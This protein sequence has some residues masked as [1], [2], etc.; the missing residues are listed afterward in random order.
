VLLIVGRYLEM[1]GVL[2]SIAGDVF[3]SLTHIIDFFVHYSFSFFSAD[4]RVFA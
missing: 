1:M 2:P 3:T 4:V